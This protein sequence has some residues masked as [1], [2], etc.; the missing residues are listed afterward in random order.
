MKIEGIERKPD[1]AFC[2]SVETTIND[3]LGKPVEEPR[4]K[5]KGN[6]P[7][8]DIGSSPILILRESRNNVSKD[9]AYTIVVGKQIGGMVL[10]Q[11]YWEMA[12]GESFGLDYHD[13]VSDHTALLVHPE[14]NSREIESHEKT[15]SAWRLYKHYGPAALKAIT[16]G[17]KTSLV[18]M[19]RWGVMDGQRKFVYSPKLQTPEGNNAINDFLKRACM[20]LPDPNVSLDPTLGLFVLAV[21]TPEIKNTWP[22]RDHLHEGGNT[23]EIGSTQA[24]LYTLMKSVT[25]LDAVML[26]KAEALVGK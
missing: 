11:I 2:E 10:N 17:S 9:S 3:L 13:V 22:K 21:A 5:S 23:R 20:E 7:L 6:L 12:P 19:L 8:T 24:P 25:L 18:P 16:N 15:K 4:N 26:P 14:L 1:F